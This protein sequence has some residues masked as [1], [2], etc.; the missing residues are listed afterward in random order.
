ML[1]QLEALAAADERKAARR[2]AKAPPA[3]D[4]PEPHHPGAPYRGERRKSAATVGWETRRRNAELRQRQTIKANPDEVS[5]GDFAY[6]LYDNAHP[7]HGDP[8]TK[9]RWES[10]LRDYYGRRV[11]VTMNGYRTN[12]ETGERHRIQIKRVRKIDGYGDMFGPG[13]VYGK[14]AKVVRNIASEDEL[15][16]TSLTL[17]L[18]DDDAEDSEDIE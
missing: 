2:A 13:S 17:E 15:V 3:P 11:L 18:A 14:M 7:L 5:A 4:R 8:D 10:I 1:A 6:Q 9:D 12:P 16:T